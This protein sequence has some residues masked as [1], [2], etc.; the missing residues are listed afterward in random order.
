MLEIIAA[1]TSTRLTTVDAVR[2]DCGITLDQASDSDVERWIDQ[3]SA[4]IVGWLGRPLALE[5]VRETLLERSS[6]DMLA[7]AR[8]PIVDI[9]SL[10]VNGTPI[11]ED[12]YAVNRA[13]GLLYRRSPTRCL[14]WPHGETVI[15]YSAGYVLPGEAGRTLPHDIERATLLLIRYGWLAQSR[16]PSIRSETEDGVG[17]TTWFSSLGTN[18]DSMPL[19][20]Q[21]LLSPYRSPAVG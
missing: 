5:T 14:F 19:E 16:D 7:L 20:V 18:S 6:T 13:A 2:A 3:Q 1:A 17:A 10:T 11:D 21:G 15:T 4:A 12:G 9:A 8:F